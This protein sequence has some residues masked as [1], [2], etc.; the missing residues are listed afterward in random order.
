MYTGFRGTLLFTR[1]NPVTQE[2]FFTLDVQGC[3]YE[4]RCTERFLQKLKARPSD[5]TE[6]TVFAHL[7]V[8][9]SELSLIG[10]EAAEERDVFRILLGASGVGIKVALAVLNQFTPQELIT[11]VINDDEKAITAIKG[12][13]SKVAK[14]LI[15]D[16][17]G[18]LK[19]MA[20]STAFSVG[21]VS[22]GHP[23]AM[24]QALQE[25]MGVLESL[26]YETPEIQ[27]ALQHIESHYSD[28]ALAAFDAEQLLRALLKAL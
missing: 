21:S 10:F 20:Q 17:Q 3:M 15:L 7:H 5:M 27:Q 28:D 23:P 4:L 16:V 25:S 22:A 19:Q 13:G 18:K 9:E 26:G 14:R 24:T 2:P 6:L 11:H 1:R 8:A 12:I